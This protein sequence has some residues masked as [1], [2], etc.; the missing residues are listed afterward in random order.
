M[1]GD[2]TASL[3]VCSILRYFLYEKLFPYV[4][5]SSSATCSHCLLPSC[6]KTLPKSVTFLHKSPCTQ[7]SAS[8]ADLMAGAR[9]WD[10][11]GFLLAKGSSHS[12]CLGIKWM[13]QG[14]CW[15]ALEE[16][17]AAATTMPRQWSSN[18][19]NISKMLLCVS[20]FSLRQQT[21]FPTLLHHLLA[22][23]LWFHFTTWL[24]L[25]TSFSG[26][27]ILFFFLLSW[28]FSGLHPGNLS[29]A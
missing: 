10:A 29:E 27:Y 20:S 13:G 9:T 1:H 6:W 22:W 28:T 18:F 21:H 26:L 7:P 17:L 4:Q 15:A 25:A 11:F 14:M 24:T 8:G 12:E 5:L 23:C 2:C 3:C 19:Q 16:T